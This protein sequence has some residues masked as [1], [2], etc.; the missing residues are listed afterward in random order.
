MPKLKFTGPISY[1]IKSLFA[2]NRIALATYARHAVGKR[3]APDW[4]ANMEIGIRFMRHQFTKALLDPNMAQG[5][6]LFES[7]TPETDDAY[8]VTLRPSTAINGLWVT[9]KSKRSE[10]VLLYLHGGGYSFGGAIAE[11]YA[12]ML[13]H[14]TK[15][16]LFMP[17]YRLTPEHPHP[18][19]ADDA[20]AAWQYLRQNTP[21][22]NIV[23]IGDSAG[24]HMALM[25]LQGLKSAGL[26]QPALCIGLCPWTDI[27]ERGASLKDNDRYDLVQGWMAIKFGHWLDPNGKFGRAALSPISHDFAG[28]APL[29]LQT[30]GREVLHDMIKDFARVQRAKGADVTLDIWPHMPH[31]FQTYDSY[32][33]DAVEA[34]KQ[35]CAKVADVER[36]AAE[37]NLP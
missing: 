1:R 11:R 12:Q 36:A 26:D 24:G 28:L 15:A 30:G 7:L 22:K 17:H 19:Q 13:A 34:L 27:G 32:Q 5:R 2:I 8:D 18:A 20:L 25:L 29:Y 33:T 10:M 4:D 16:D 37:P 3:I 21:A 9:P 35:I 31:N 23:V 6:L 14:H